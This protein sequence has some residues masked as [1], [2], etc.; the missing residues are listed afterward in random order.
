MLYFRQAI[1]ADL[2]GTLGRS[3]YR[4]SLGTAHMRIA[5]PKAARL[6]AVVQDIFQMARDYLEMASNATTAG[7]A[8][9]MP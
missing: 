6:S 1:P 2:R 5:R 7:K 8:S 3:E 4:K 9:E